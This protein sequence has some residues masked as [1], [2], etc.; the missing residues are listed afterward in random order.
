[1]RNIVTEIISIAGGRRKLAEMHEV[2]TQSV[3]LW[4]RQGYFPL[5]Q[6]PTILRNFKEVTSEQL[7]NAYEAYLNHKDGYDD[8]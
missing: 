6:M 2:T 1:M 7:I 8:N 5:K 4:E 3:V